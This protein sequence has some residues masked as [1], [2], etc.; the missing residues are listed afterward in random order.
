MLHKN[1]MTCIVTDFE[2][3]NETLNYIVG[4]N[5]T[6]CFS[7]R[8]IPDIALQDNKQFQI[9]IS[10]NQQTERVDISQA[11]VTIVDYNGKV[12]CAC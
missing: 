6:M 11:I 9:H 4:G 7:I 12:V 8:I 10:P 3:L 5:T 1:T 2:P